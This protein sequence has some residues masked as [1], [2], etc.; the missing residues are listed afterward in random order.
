MIEVA[1]WLIKFIDDKIAK[2]SDFN[3]ITF[4]TQIGYDKN[5]KMPFPQNILS[6]ISDRE[7]TPSTTFQGEQ[8]NIIALQLM[9]FSEIIVINGEA[10]T[11][12][13]AVLFI[14]NKMKRYFQE[15]KSERLNRNILS[16]RR[17]GSTQA[18]PAGEDGNVYVG[19]NRFELIV[20]N[21]YSELL[22]NIQKYSKK[23]K[24]KK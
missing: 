7:H 5:N 8:A 15:L 4:H 22:I 2:D 6:G 21:N 23:L 20:V 14:T 9:N 17:V 12:H 10:L 11:P 13:E 19:L 16:I 3:G 1:N 18:M 24:I